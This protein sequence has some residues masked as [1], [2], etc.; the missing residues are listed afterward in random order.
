MKLI[1]HDIILSSRT[2]IYIFH[3]NVEVGV[4]LKGV[5]QSLR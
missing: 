5:C 2:Y 4:E 3:I 1:Q